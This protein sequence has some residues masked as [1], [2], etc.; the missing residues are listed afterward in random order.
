MASDSA[1]PPIRA[2][3]QVLRGQQ[4]SGR[5]PR[6]SGMSALVLFEDNGYRALL[7]LTYWRT[8]FELRVGRHIQLDR[9]PQ[10]L[11]LP[12][13]G[14]W[15]REWMEAVARQR[16]GTAVNTPLAPET[17]LASGRWLVDAPPE[18]P[19]APVV[20]RLGEGI[21]FI[22]CDARLARELCPQDFLRPEGL[23]DKLR[24]V[25]EVPA[26]GRLIRYPWDIVGGLADRLRG[27]WKTDD[28]SVEAELDSRVYAEPLDQICVGPRSTIH[29]SAVI[30][31]RPG[32]VYISHDVVV[33][34]AAVIEGPAYIGP[35]THVRPH[36]YLHGGVAAGP[37]GRLGGEIDGCVIH[38]YSNKQ[39]AGFLGHSYVG[40]WVNLGAG[41]TNSDLKNTYGNV[42]VPIGGVEMDTGT[43]FFGA[44]IGDHVKVGINAT[45]PTGVVLGFAATVA[46]P[47]ALPKWVPSFSWVDEH[48]IKEGNA[49]KLLDGACKVMARRDLDM[50]D[51]EVELFLDLGERTRQ[52]ERIGSAS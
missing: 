28:A 47:R 16:C 49:A 12:V 5:A 8:V 40:S 37:V 26:S 20:G 27:D 42:R 48:G 38:G 22:H 30:D 29:P 15:T 3:G 14:V 39:H 34:A 45:L 44:V 4:G 24:H 33:G 6:V 11:G 36:A 32:P 10:Q 23:E 35:G 25:D 51:S 17:L 46:S 2:P 18:I 21:A 13:S 19:K 7:P 9:L 31:A 50:T 1:R 43:M 52:L 41:A